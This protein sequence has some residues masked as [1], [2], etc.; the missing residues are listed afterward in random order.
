M[1]RTTAERIAKLE[2]IRDQLEDRLADMTVRPK[3]SYN[4][5]GQQFSFNEY[6]K[7]LIDAIKSLDELLVGLDAISGNGRLSMTQ[8]FTGG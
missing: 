1:A 2:T 3:V 5:E 6:Q 4:V 7:M 8:V